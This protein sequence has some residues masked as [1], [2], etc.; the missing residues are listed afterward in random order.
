MRHIGLFH[1]I[2]W[3][4]AIPGKVRRRAQSLRSCTAKWHHSLGTVV[5]SDLEDSLDHASCRSEASTS[6]VITQGFRLIEDTK[7]H[8]KS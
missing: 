5:S 4:F 6:P 1:I 7:I 8:S 3:Y 2:Y